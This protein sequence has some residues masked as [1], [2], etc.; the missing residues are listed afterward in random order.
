MGPEVCLPCCMI[1]HVTI[2]SSD[3]R[4]PVEPHNATVTTIP[5]DEQK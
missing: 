1:V 5:P 3:A 2:I 4:D